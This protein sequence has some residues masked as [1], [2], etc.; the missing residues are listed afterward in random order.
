VLNLLLYSISFAQKSIEKKDFLTIIKE[1]RNKFEEIQFYTADFV[2]EKANKISGKG[3]IYY[4]KPNLLR[5]DYY[6]VDSNMFEGFSLHGKNE[7]WW[8]VPRINIAIKWPRNNIGNTNMNVILSDSGIDNYKNILYINKTVINTNECYVF[9]IKNEK[10]LL[11]T[12]VYFEKKRG[13][14]LKIVFFD[15]NGNVKTIRRFN[16]FDTNTPID[17]TIFVFEPPV[18]VIVNDMTNQ[19]GTL[20]KVRG[21]IKGL[22]K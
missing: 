14:I 7:R 4:K 2:I 12:E 8:Y 16:N 21:K 11:D 5:S 6:D 1:I 15:D 13:L 9:G 10:N 20:M 22:K 17:N 19:G 18:Y 3:K